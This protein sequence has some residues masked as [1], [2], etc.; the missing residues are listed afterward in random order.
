MADSAQRSGDRLLAQQTAL[1]RF[2]ELALHSEDLQ[3]IL[4]DACRL[5]AEGLET[6]LAKVLALQPDGR[7]LLVVA[8]VGWEPGVVGHAVLRADPGTL[9][10]CALADPDPLVCADTE[11]ET[12]YRIAPFMEAHGVRSFVNVLVIG[13]DGR[14]PWGMLEV[15]SREPREFDADETAFLQ[16]YANML[17]AA[18]DRLRSG[19]ELRARAADVERL[20]RELQ[21]RV[22]NNLQVIVGLMQLQSRRATQPETLE[23]LR[24]VSQ[25][26]DALRLLHDKLYLAG[27]VDR[28][29]LGAYL[30]ELAGTLL[31]FHAAEERQVR[32]VLEMRRMI[33]AP[34]QAAPLGLIVNEFITNSLKYAFEGPD[35]TV[36]LRLEPAR[37]GEARLILWDDGRGLPDQR[38]GGTGMRLIDGLARQLSA[39]VDWSP[40]GRGTRLS[41]LLKGPRPA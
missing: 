13:A 22:K 36:G 32:L 19:D 30:G 18:V 41:L 34:E 5:V 28:V 6:G 10:A 35:G 9:E 11:A 17:A 12:R 7:T 29:D 16:T 3:E 38:A 26:V 24:V 31:R 37:G 39:R 1:A 25:R 14:P 15:D 2:G 33:A 21:H 27:D 23:A 4:H 8:G 40:T 20:F